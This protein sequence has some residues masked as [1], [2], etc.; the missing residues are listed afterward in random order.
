MKAHSF[1]ASAA[2]TSFDHRDYSLGKLAAPVDNPQV[3]MQE[4]A[5]SAPIYY[6]GQ[7]PACGAHAGAWLKALLDSYESKPRKYTPRFTWADIK[8][9]DGFNIEDG[10]DMRSIFKSLAN[11]GALDYG[12]LENDQTLSLEDYAHPF[13]TQDM[14]DNAAPKIIKTYGFEHGITFDSLKKAIYQNKGVIA[15]MEIGDEWWSRDGKNTWAEKDILPLRTPQT[16]V[17]GHFVVLHSY[18]ENYIYFANS[19][20]EK[21]G[22]KGH[23]YFGPDYI[24]YVTDAGTAVDIP[25]ELVPALIKTKSLLERILLLLKKKMGIT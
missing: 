21:W 13:I 20:S 14:R 8:S 23:G 2:N 17:G 10:T 11:S 1:K 7:Q 3:F 9:F 25:D 15:R 6:Q 18:D 5:W 24:P 22:K 19:F 16:S 12:L 4:N